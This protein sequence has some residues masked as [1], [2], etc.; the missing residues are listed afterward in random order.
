MTQTI[1][2]GLHIVEGSPWKEAVIA[3][4]EADSPYPPWHYAFGEACEGV[5]VAMILDTDPASCGPTGS[6]RLYWS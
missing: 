5:P 1:T 3:L 6:R 4:L 2:E